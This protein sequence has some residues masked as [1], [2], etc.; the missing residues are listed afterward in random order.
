MM[1]VKEK[2]FFHSALLLFFTITLFSIT[3]F[4]YADGI[5]NPLQAETWQEL[6]GQIIKLLFSFVGSAALVMFVWGGFLW[7]TAAGEENRIK[8]GWST[9]IWAAIG[10][11]VIFGAY[12][13][14]NTLIK[15]AVGE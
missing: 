11:I 4:A 6:I 12:A 1:R 2:I 10:L 15:G 9:M 8:Q 13:F 7:L 5:S 14:L 3:S